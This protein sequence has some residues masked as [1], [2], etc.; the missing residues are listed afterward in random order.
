MSIAL[1]FLTYDNIY[2]LNDYKKKGYFSDC[3]IYIH[4]KK[5]QDVI[6]SLHKYIIS[7]NIPTEWGTFSI[8]EA[9]LALLKNAYINQ[10]N[11]WFVLL[12]QDSYPLHTS[13]EIRQKLSQNTLSIFDEMPF[14]NQTY[15]KASQWWVL[16]REDVNT[17]ITQFEGYSRQ[18]QNFESIQ[19]AAVDEVFFLSLLSSVNTNYRYHNKKTHL[20]HWL[21]ES[22]ASHPTIF[23]RLLP[24][25]NEVIAT[26]DP[27]F[28][29]K[30]L[31]TFTVDPF[32]PSKEAA[33]CFIGTETTHSFQPI[34]AAGM[35]LYVIYVKTVNDVEKS[36]PDIM[37][38]SKLI[39]LY[40]SNWRY[41]ILSCKQVL[42]RISKTIDY[43]RI[44]TISEKFNPKDYS[45]SEQQG[46]S[47]LGTHILDRNQNVGYV[48]INDSK[49]AV[50]DDKED[51]NTKQKGESGLISNDTGF[52][53]LGYII[54]L[55]A[56]SNLEYHQQTFI[57]VY[58]SPTLIK[59][60]NTS[61]SQNVSLILNDLS[62]ITEESITEIKILSRD[63]EKGFARQNR[64]LPDT[65][66]DIR[67]SGDVPFIVT[68]Q[69]QF[70]E[71]DQIEIKSYPDN[72]TFYI[73]FQY[74][75][76]PIDMPIEEIIIRNSPTQNRDNSHL[77]TSPIDN[78]IEEGEIEITT[79]DTGDRIY[80]KPKNIRVDQ[81][82]NEYINT[83]LLD[84]TEIFGESLD[85]IVRS[86]EITEKEKKYD[87]Q[88]QTVSMVD[89]F[90][91]KIPHSQRTMEVKNKV[92]I[93][94]E[95]YKQL[96]TLFSTV[97]E[98][99]NITGKKIYGDSYK[100][101]V[102]SLIKLDT[103]I[104]W[105]MPIVSAKRKLYVDATEYNAS[106]DH[107]STDFNT[108]NYEQ[109]TKDDA[110]KI[111]KF[112]NDTATGDLNNYDHYLHNVDEFT[113]N[114]M[115]MVSIQD[116][117]MV[118][119]EIKADIEMLI[120][121]S[122]DFS[123]TSMG[124]DTI[125]DSK[126][127]IQRYN[128]GI[129]RVSDLTRG[130]IPIQTKVIPNPKVD[131]RGL[132]MFPMPVVKY[133]QVFLPGSDIMTK[134]SLSQQSVHISK[135]LNS[136]RNLNIQMVDSFDNELVYDDGDN[137][138]KLEEIVPFLKYVNHYVL[139]GS[140]YDNPSE[141]VYAQ[142]LNVIIPKIKPIIRSIRSSIQDRFS[143]VRVV[144]ALEPFQIYSENIT[145]SQ[146]TEITSFINKM[147]KEYKTNYKNA[148]SEFILLRNANIAK[149]HKKY[150]PEISHFFSTN[151]ETM[152]TFKEMYKTNHKLFDSEI[153]NSI[154][155]TDN[156][157][158][159]SD[160]I[161]YSFLP[162][163]I[164]ESITGIEKLNIDDMTFPEQNV[165]KCVRRVLAKRYSSMDDLQKDNTIDDVFFDKDLDDTPY[166][167][168]KQYSK[169][170]LSMEPNQFLSFLS[171]VLIQKHQVARVLAT[172][173]A[174]TL[175]LGKRRV[176]DE[177]FAILKLVPTLPSTVNQDKLTQKEKQ[178][179]QTEQETR[180][181]YMYYVRKSNHW[182]HDPSIESEAFIMSNELF[183]NLDSKC[184]NNN[185]LGV[186][187][188]AE[189]SNIRMKYLTQKKILN[190]VDRRYTISLEDMTKTVSD[191]IL[192]QTKII[193]RLDVINKINL[194]RNNLVCYEIGKTLQKDTNIKS[195]FEILRD[196][197]LSQPDFSKKQ[198]DICKFVEK[199]CRHP[200]TDNNESPNWYYCIRTS[201]P[202][203]PM[204][205]YLLA[206]SFVYDNDYISR[207]ARVCRE[208]GV[209]SDDGDSV[210]DKYSGY[211]LKSN[212]YANEDTFDDSGL[213]IM[214]NELFAQDVSEKTV[215]MSDRPQ[216]EP[217]A[218]N[219][220]F[221]N[222]TLGVYQ[223]LSSATNLKVQTIKD[224]VMQYTVEIVSN[225][226]VLFSETYYNA[227]VEI[228]TAAKTKEK[229]KQMATYEFYREQVIIVCTTAV[230][231]VAI[232][233]SV[234]SI[235]IKKSFLDCKRS[236]DGYPLTGVEDK[237]GIDYLG[238]L[239]YKTKN[240]SPVLRSI[241]KL[242]QDA[243]QKRIFD[244][245]YKVITQHPNI[246]E[247]IKAK[248]EYLLTHVDITEPPKKHNL[249]KWVNFLPPVIP[250]SVVTRLSNTSKEYDAE[251]YS[252]IQKGNKDAD[253]HINMHKSKIMQHTYGV[254]ELI[255]DI[256]NNKELLLVSKNIPYKDN[257]CCNENFIKKPMTYFIEENKS[258]ESFIT[259]SIKNEYITHNINKR[260]KPQILFNNESTRIKRPPVSQAFESTDVYLSFFHY[261]NFDNDLPIPVDLLPLMREK[262]SFYDKDAPVVERIEMMKRHG[263]QLSLENLYQLLQVVNRRK[264]ISIQSTVPQLPIQMFKDYIE[265]LE[266][267]HSTIISEPLR[268]RVL[269]VL[270][271]YNPTQ[272]VVDEPTTA[273]DFSKA[274]L[275]LKNYLIKS[276]ERM[277]SKISEFID[278]NGNLNGRELENVMQYITNIC[279]W[280]IDKNGSVFISN[281]F[282][283]NTIYKMTSVYPNK[284]LNINNCSTG[285]N[286]DHWKLGANHVNDITSVLYKKSK[287]LKKFN[288]EKIII[289]FL[290]S[291]PL[292]SSELNKF[293]QLIP[294]QS[295]IEIDNQ[296]YYSLFSE[297][298]LELL[299]SHCWYSYLDEWIEMSNEKNLL[300][301]D[302]IIRK[303]QY[304]EETELAR[305]TSEQL[306]PE[307]KD[308]VNDN[309]EEILDGQQSSLREMVCSVMLTFIN[310][311]SRI[312]THINK[313]YSQISRIGKITK[314]KEKAN[315][316]KSFADMSKDVR[317]VQLKLKQHRV[318]DWN[319][320]KGVHKYDKDTYNKESE[321][322]ASFKDKPTSLFGEL[323]DASSEDESDNDNAYEDEEAERQEQA[324]E[325]GGISGISHMPANFMDGNVDNEYPDYDDDL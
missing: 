321:L 104:K 236:F 35:D 52:I 105:L 103:K 186:C 255:N 153:I 260:T 50:I 16:N 116:D 171:E 248:K 84:S 249:N 173:I 210:V 98:Y 189:F 92:H 158:L 216:K 296:Y 315:V 246:V 163:L 112:F 205:L 241:K 306:Y 69:I 2:H 271:H 118:R 89:E 231:L 219:N 156:A 169:E 235:V 86:V 140:L 273:T 4:P 177:E 305:D 146:Y 259:Q 28:V 77:Y 82:I 45:T 293:V 78:S 83:I 175:I 6:S 225:Q 179:I 302:F 88:N 37:A 244:M 284:I 232:Q 145:Y 126:N 299:F 71:E 310:A 67:F 25:D 110:K 143:F 123:S 311:E 60:L 220:I 196:R 187:E 228:Q 316:V 280:S 195:P 297:F 62:Q 124:K 54:Q 166:G 200:I 23:N 29:R 285:F 65:W 102:D 48:W 237:S 8:I 20:L 230:F 191:N 149:L 154:L 121:S 250:F 111:N 117:V 93:M 109:D 276:N 63:T 252:L 1:L 322:F 72:N 76:I 34:L 94:V 289:P 212:E 58:C 96:R 150:T 13:E 24:V 274:T 66:V 125:I 278:K 190:E 243:I 64:L 264:D 314:E 120:A 119:Q 222:I 266:L 33:I 247:L 18:H 168:I 40:N 139:N 312:K 79:T 298:T 129:S 172:E 320:G 261:C 223:F 183:C 27:F 22:G 134:T 178:A 238:C 128:L 57:V 99:G 292:R 193:K 227:Q 253:S 309:Y 42:E 114:L 26:E 106:R 160:L 144:K 268:K 68:G 133:S 3:N 101:L 229:E 152:N 301:I 270:S 277:L 267:S 300:D 213:K 113:T 325:E 38:Y 294:V 161:Q 288:S 257:A 100:P 141:S 61:T 211:V 233:T 12:S 59:L 308:A 14:V 286:S 208:Y 283:K 240:D 5:R 194:Y 214:S 254:V 90:L 239:L 9:T 182:I 46:K 127:F 21:T 148:S 10:N 245:I 202:L 135:I 7:E 192:Y 318:G 80:N 170:K 279:K 19:N 49:A 73:D 291:L 206:K 51:S 282:L 185:T 55:I 198:N 108:F 234:P 32:V 226:D 313:P 95:R 87:I 115:S 97:D 159:F 155:K 221:A 184:F 174:S 131:V 70:I 295:S 218:Y 256:V 263:Q 176:Q 17:V 209:L 130:K 56:P 319:T 251:T 181:K 272:M 290:N 304:A 317:Q 324:D 197:I 107:T 269:D 147:I 164:P 43:D 303:N 165:E 15:K 199:C 265:H 180:T 203:F 275:K 258:I 162:Y 281:Q 53:E 167:I 142:F 157:K 41:Q 307:Q 323:D 136:K 30:T 188:P 217:A 215:D 47:E 207:L 262:P 137:S 204:S 44:Y 81:P 242:K 151:N 201:I 122:D 85:D 287:V 224:F 74:R 75:G 36:H 132:L 11:E 91:S 138:N 39:Q 31:K